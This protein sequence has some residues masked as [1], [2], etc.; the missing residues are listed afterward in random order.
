MQTVKLLRG[1]DQKVSGS[2]NKY[3]ELKIES[4]FLIPVCNAES[5]K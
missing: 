1:R 5:D 2:K 4:R 3:K